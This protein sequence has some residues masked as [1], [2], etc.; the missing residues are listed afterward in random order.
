MAIVVLRRKR[1]RPPTRTG[2][3]AKSASTSPRL[4]S[5][6]TNTL[7]PASSWSKG[8]SG[9]TACSGSIDR[10]EV[11]ELDVDQFEGVLSQVA[12]LRE[13]CDDWLADVANLVPRQRVNRR[14]MVVLHARGRAHRREVVQLGGRVDG[15][16]SRHCRSGSAVNRQDASMGAI[17]SPESDMQRVGDEAVI[18]ELPCPASRRGSSTRFMRAPTFRGRRPRSTSPRPQSSIISVGS[19]PERRPLPLVMAAQ[20]GRAASLDALDLGERG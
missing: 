12:V 16:D 8:A 9:R 19:L 6:R 7:V 18:G 14:R 20:H 13:H 1:K 5:R 4:N 17:A 3:L 10:A 11:S 15:D 2:A